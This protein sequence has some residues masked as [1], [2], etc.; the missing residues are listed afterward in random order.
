MFRTDPAASRTRSGRRKICDI[1]TDES[2]APYTDDRPEM[3]TLR[4]Q[5]NQT[6]TVAATAAQTPRL[7]PWRR[8]TDVQTSQIGNI[9]PTR[10][11]AVC[12]CRSVAARRCKCSSRAAQVQALAAPHLQH[13]QSRPV[14][15]RIIA[16]HVQRITSVTQS[17]VDTARD[18]TRRIRMRA[19][20]SVR[21]LRAGARRYR[22]EGS[23]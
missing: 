22:S 15:C 13:L 8:I 10:R 11:S 7:Q 9:A 16:A 1:R 20:G 19:C 5:S 2:Y 6:K 14:V 23:R 18:R 17:A 12:G 4:P 21:L 3:D